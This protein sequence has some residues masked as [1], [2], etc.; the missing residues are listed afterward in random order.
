MLFFNGFVT[1]IE[2][3]YIFP[4][5]CRIWAFEIV[6][7]GISENF[8]FLGMFSTAHILNMQHYMYQNRWLVHIKK[9]F[10]GVILEQLLEFPKKTLVLQ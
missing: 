4:S 7:D 2:P 9:P 1:H 10:H 3:D 8:S 6:L 5:G